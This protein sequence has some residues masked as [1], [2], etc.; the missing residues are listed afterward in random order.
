LRAH[1]EGR[2]ELVVSGTL[3]DAAQR[4]EVVRLAAQQFPNSQPQLQ[5]EVVPPPI[6][7]SL[8]ELDALRRAGVFTDTRLSV[9]L[10]NGGAELHEG[11]AIKVLVSGPGYPAQARIDYF[12]LDG[13]VL[14]LWPTPAEPAAKLDPSGERLFWDAG[15]GKTWDAG[16]A[17]FGTEAIAAIVTATPLALGAR[18]PIE[19]ASTYLRDVQSALL[20]IPAS[21]ETPNSVATFLVKTSPRRPPG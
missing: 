5:L 4:S 15:G 13:N 10:A 19:P 16:G 20:R 17:P 12:S 1:L 14:H 21:T 2:G 6:C 8:A 18:A 3:P 11:E 9:K 7:R